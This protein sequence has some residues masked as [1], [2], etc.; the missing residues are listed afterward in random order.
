MRKNKFRSLSLFLFFAAFLFCKFSYSQVTIGRV[1][2]SRSKTP[3]PGVYISIN[4]KPITATD[5]NGLF[6]LDKVQVQAND[7][8]SFSHLIY[9]YKE[10]ISPKQKRD[11]LTVI[12][13]TNCFDLE[14]VDVVESKLKHIIKKA[15]K[16]FTQKY[17]PINCW[18][19]AKYQHVLLENGKV[20]N[21]MESHG[22][23]MLRKV[24][25]RAYGGQP[26]FVEKHTRRTKMHGSKLFYQNKKSPVS[27]PFVN[28]D[29]SLSE[30]GFCQRVLP[31]GNLNF[32]DYRFKLDSLSDSS[33]NLYVISFV[34]KTMKMVVGGWRLWGASGKIWLNVYSIRKIPTVALE[35]SPV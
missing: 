24:G 2:D 5:E 14:E 31:L 19:Q 10:F 7:T 25:R 35:K 17:Q 11:T 26:L 8:L 27:I 13:K 15:H 18:T 4:H 12:L 32:R 28:F 6:N 9:E 23:A 33:K 34:Q 29:L 16:L 21:F 1:I 22:H 3:I 20:V 30:Y